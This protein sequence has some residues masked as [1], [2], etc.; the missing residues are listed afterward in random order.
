MYLPTPAFFEL[1]RFI[2]ME[3]LEGS[4]DLTVVLAKTTREISHG[5]VSDVP[6]GRNR[7]ME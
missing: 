3:P 5:L 6:R 1:L 7:S 2:A 4:P